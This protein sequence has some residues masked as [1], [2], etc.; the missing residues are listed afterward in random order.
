MIPI[1]VF[2]QGNR[3]TGVMGRRT[4]YR[5]KTFHSCARSWG[6]KGL[7]VIL[8]DQGKSQSINLRSQTRPTTYKGSLVG[9]SKGSFGASMGAVK[10]LVV[11]LGPLLV[12][13]A[14]SWGHK[15]DMERK[16]QR[17]AGKC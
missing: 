17:H 14:S 4:Y 11:G 2:S 10:C 5:N 7:K 3:V 6:S 15:L 13:R 16:K 12:S 8:A 1:T 9:R